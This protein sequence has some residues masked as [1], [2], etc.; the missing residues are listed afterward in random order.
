MALSNAERQAEFRRRRDEEF[1][2]LRAVAGESRGLPSDHLIRAILC[3]SRQEFSL[4][5]ADAIC[6][7]LFPDDRVTPLILKGTTV[8]ADTTTSGWASQL[9]ATAVAD[10]L[11]TVGPATAAGE[12][13][14]RGTVL[15]FDSYNQINVPTIIS[16]ATD[17]AWTVQGAPQPVRQLVV[18]AGATLVPRT[19]RVGFVVT[20]EL[21]EHTNAE[22]LIRA[23]V[24]ESVANALD[25]AALDA[26]AASTAR[27]AGLRNGVST[28]TAT[29]GGGDLAM[30]KD[31]GQLAAGVAGVGGMDI[32]FVASPGEAVKIAL[33]AGPEFSFPVFASGQ[34][35][36]G[37]VMAVALPALVAAVDP[38]VTFDVRRDGAAHFEDTSPLPISTTPTPITAPVKSFYQHDLLGFRLKLNASWG[39]R[40]AGSVAWLSAV[41]W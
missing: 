33:R 34:L 25:A 3:Q 13:F 32:A 38:E 27:P 6:K 10:L 14:R 12:L 20:R 22:A 26:T 1:R 2:Q 30:M 9:A 21:A 39:V 41:T 7:Q 8:P 23:V 36:S 24:V 5:R 15:R 40:A 37:F 17:A 19:L 11:T 29:V 18:G 28:L 4:G 35:A 16:S 31:L